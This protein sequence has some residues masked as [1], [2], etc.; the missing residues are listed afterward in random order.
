MNKIV[1]RVVIFMLGARMHYAV[2]KILYQEGLLWTFYTDTYFEGTKFYSFVYR[3]FI[4][5]G[6]KKLSLRWK[7]RS[8]DIIP[9]NKIVNF[10]LFGLKYALKRRIFSKEPII[11]RVYYKTNIAFNKIILK[12]GLGEANVVYGFNSASLEVFEFA[13]RNNIKCILEQTILP[14]FKENQLLQEASTK[15]GFFNHG[16]EVFNEN[17]EFA[18]RE[19]K[20]WALA[21]LIIAGS[22]FV[23]KGLI[24]CGVLPHKIKVIP[25]GVHFNNL[26]RVQNNFDCQR[27]LNVLFIG[28][29]GLRKGVP[30]LLKA[31]EL[32]GPSKIVAKFVG[33]LSIVEEEL[34]HFS[35]I[36]EFVGTIP[37]S[38]VHDFYKWADVFVLPSIVEGSATVTYEALMFGLPL[39]VTPNCGSVIKDE[40]HGKV[41]P[42]FC[43]ESI[44]NALEDYINNPNKLKEHS[45]NA[46]SLKEYISFD[47]YKSDLISAI[48]EITNY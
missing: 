39:I 41:I 15:L 2:P 43:V 11:S 9:L 47:R 5:F 29:V 20:E 22:E 42:P 18:I 28:E 19:S 24:E 48:N 12:R 37:R 8:V 35:H 45:K 16:Y 30:F 36:V 17:M 6:F 1:P 32:L 44:V 14:K 7:G 38:E 31:L 4:F 25:Y 33:K 23:K 27:P 34:N 10:D 40:I 3:I 21:D 46:L 13:K 26:D